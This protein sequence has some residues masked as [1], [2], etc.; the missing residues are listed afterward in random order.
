MRPVSA[1]AAILLALLAGEP[2]AA[3]QPSV[4]I[5]TSQGEIRVQLDPDRAPETV[6]NFLSYVD[7]GFYDGTIV[8]RVIPG[9][10][11][12]GGGFTPDYR[13][14]STRDPIPNEADKGLAN[15]RGTIAMARTKNPHSATAQFFINHADNPF[16]DH[17][18]KDE[19]GFGYAVFGKVTAGME[20]VDAIAATP[21]GP[22]GPFAT[23]APQT[24]VL[25]EKITRLD[26][27]T[28]EDH[29]QAHH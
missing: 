1:T 10:M 27:R 14:K 9:F 15:K 17:S 18:A 3:D 7:A 13:Q 25:I 28:G 22:A 19:R 8:H 23:D 2:A 12:Q 24:Q 4:S 21:T 5:L 26:S 6:A 29:D 20:V 16:L 11:I